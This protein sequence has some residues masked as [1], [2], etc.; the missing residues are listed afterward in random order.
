MRLP[1]S[2]CPGDGRERICTQCPEP[3][4]LS[5]SL[6][7][8]GWGSAEDLQMSEVPW[9]PRTQPL[10]RSALCV[11]LAQAALSPPCPCPAFYSPPSPSLSLSLCA[12]VCLCLSPSLLPSF[13]LS[14]FRPHPQFFWSGG[15]EQ[16]QPAAGAASR[17]LIRASCELG[18]GWGWWGW[19]GWRG[20]GDCKPPCEATASAVSGALLGCG[21]PRAMI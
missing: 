4:P 6:M 13:C 18:R 19:G 12:C 5:I 3:V 16:Q 20:S 14:P 9:P 11:L 21:I 7:Q 15:W 10:Q 8:V 2:P 17:S 1:T